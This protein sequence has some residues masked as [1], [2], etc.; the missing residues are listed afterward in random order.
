MVT[1]R[2]RDCSSL[3]LSALDP[4]QALVACHDLD[5]HLE[6]DQPRLQE[7][8]RELVLTADVGRSRRRPARVCLGN[9]W[10]A[11]TNKF[12]LELLAGVMRVSA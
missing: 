4:H 7:G 1:Y 2:H 11:S 6:I 8:Q 10:G 3:S 5:L 9:R 12:K